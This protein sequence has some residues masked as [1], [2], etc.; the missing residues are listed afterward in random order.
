MEIYGEMGEE[1]LDPSLSIF[2]IVPRAHRMKPTVL[3][4]MGELNA[5]EVRRLIESHENIYFNTA[6]SN[7]IAVSK[8]AQP[9]VNLFIG[10]TLAPDWRNLFILYSDR[11][12]LGFDNVFSQHWRKL[13]VKQAKLWKKALKD[14]PE[15][16]A[17]AVAHGNSERLWRLMPLKYVYQ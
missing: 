8:S 6:M 4:H 15:S 17:H 16:V 7:P 5:K 2:Q 11:F 14:L 10:E 12:I 3:M 13:Y 9:L 1:G